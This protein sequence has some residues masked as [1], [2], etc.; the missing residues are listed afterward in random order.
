MLHVSGFVCVCVRSSTLLSL[1]G[2]AYLT[3]HR[4]SHPTFNQPEGESHF[5]SLLIAPRPPN[6]LPTSSHLLPGL[7]SLTSWLSEGRSTGGGA[8]AGRR[9]LP[10]LPVSMTTARR[11]RIRAVCY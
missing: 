6:G 5:P 10:S 3:E 4:A 7:L 9:E 8:A 2:V 1:R 11:R